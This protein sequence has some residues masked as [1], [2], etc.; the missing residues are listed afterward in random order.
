MGRKSFG[1]SSRPLAI[2]E[3]F[4]MVKVG[5]SECEFPKL[6]P[7]SR[8]SAMA[9]AVRGVTMRPRRP[10]GTNRIRL[11]GTGFCA[12]AAPTVSVI[13]LADS[14]TTVRRIGFSPV[15]SNFGDRPL[16]PFSFALR[17]NCYIGREPAQEAEL[18]PARRP[19][20]RSLV[21]ST[22]NN[23]AFWPFFPERRLR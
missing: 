2:A 18:R 14:N 12:E 16:P 19:K 8:T 6:T 10:S 21:H 17:Q 9:G 4:A 1:V 20:R 5:N 13:R 11:R 15:R 3:P 22:G 7:L 23:A